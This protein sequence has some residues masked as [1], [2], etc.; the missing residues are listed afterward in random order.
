MTFGLYLSSCCF[1]YNEG[2]SGYIRRNYALQIR[3]NSQ[4]VQH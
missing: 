3:K 4:E 2:M 1:Y